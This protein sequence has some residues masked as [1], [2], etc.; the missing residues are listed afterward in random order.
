M[1]TLKRIVL[2][3]LFLALIGIAYNFALGQGQNFPGAVVV[4]NI[5][6]GSATP[7]ATGAHCTIPTTPLSQTVNQATTAASANYYNLPATTVGYK[8]CVTNG[9]TGSTATTGVLSIT[10]P[11]GSYAVYKGVIGTVSSTV[12]SA[13]AAGDSICFTAIDTTHWLAVAELGTW[14]A[15]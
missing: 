7:C 11:T 12:T 3:L 5:T 14:T 6:G 13:G 8:A 1:I 2:V 9:S 10:V 4:V 15:N